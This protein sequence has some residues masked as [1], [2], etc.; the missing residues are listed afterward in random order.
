MGSEIL[1]S[2]N[3]Q[4]VFTESQIEE[5]CFGV[6]LGGLENGSFRIITVELSNRLAAEAGFVIDD[7]KYVKLRS[8]M[9]VIQNAR[10]AIE[11]W[12][13]GDGLARSLCSEHTRYEQTQAKRQHCGEW[14][15]PSPR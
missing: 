2:A 3:I 12:S 5:G 4:I 15:D 8:L 13:R 11:G 7:D 14:Y 9:Q 10:K 6:P 1:D